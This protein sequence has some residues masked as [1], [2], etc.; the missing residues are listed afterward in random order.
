MVMVAFRSIVVAATLVAVPAFAQ[1]AQ[2]HDAHHPDGAP[3][4]QGQVTA[5]AA[6]QAGMM[7][8]GT[9]GGNMMGGGQT[10]S[11][12]MMSMMNMMMGARSGAEHIEGRLAFIKTEL[13]I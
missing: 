12:G 13:K 1:P 3:G 7:G 10:G 6:P 11:G 8:P 5:P 4:T 2:D 9:M